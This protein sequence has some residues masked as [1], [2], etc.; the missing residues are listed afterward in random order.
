MTERDLGDLIAS[1]GDPDLDCYLTGL[2]LTSV[3]A[4]DG[5]EYDLEA[6]LSFDTSD[7]TGWWT[8][9][10]T[11]EQV[12]PDR[13]TE[14]NMTFGLA[15]AEGF[16]FLA[17]DLVR[18]LSVWST[19]RALITMTAAPG[20]WNFLYCPGHPAGEQAIVPRSALPSERETNA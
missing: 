9:S 17:E 13:V 10:A 16:A 1:P 12:Y 3:V 4:T 8:D 5:T 18:R 7:A 14:L 2:R 15:M 20:K 19:D 6:T 11:G